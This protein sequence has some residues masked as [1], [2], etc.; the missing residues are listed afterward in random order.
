[1]HLCIVFRA[2]CTNI[3][4]TLL[5]VDFQYNLSVCMHHSTELCTVQC[6]NLCSTY[7]GHVL[8]CIYV[9]YMHC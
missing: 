6:V 1:M 4:C 5:F 3:P 2:H 9:H 8:L 7:A